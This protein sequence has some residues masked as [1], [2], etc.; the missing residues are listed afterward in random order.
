M[1]FSDDILS[2]VDPILF[3]WF[4]EWLLEGFSLVVAS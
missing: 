3:R 4:V 2:A 1:F